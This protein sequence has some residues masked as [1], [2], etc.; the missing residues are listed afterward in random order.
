M[1]LGDKAAGRPCKIFSKFFSEASSYS[2]PEWLVRMGWSGVICPK[3]L[4]CT[5]FSTTMLGSTARFGWLPRW[6]RVSLIDL[7]YG[8]YRQAD[9]RCR[10]EAWPARFIQ[11]AG[12]SGRN[13][14]LRQCPV[15]TFVALIVLGVYDV[16]ASDEASRT[17]RG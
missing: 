16:G 1:H 6:R 4:R 5:R 7:G 8:K 11:E 9:R 2:H 17:T 10:T 12:E 15:V 13:F 3:W 14:K